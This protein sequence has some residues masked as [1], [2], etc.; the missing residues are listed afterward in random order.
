MLLIIEGQRNVGKTT[1]IDAFIA[2]NTVRTSPLWGRKI[3]KLSKQRMQFP[4]VSMMR[5]WLPAAFDESSIFILDRGHLTEQVYT[6]LTGRPVTWTHQEMSWAEYFLSNANAVTVYLNCDPQV[7][8]NR[9]ISTGKESEGEIFTI[10][11]LFEIYY[12]RTP[13][14]KYKIDVTEMAVDKV[15]KQLTDITFDALKNYKRIP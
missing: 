4:V 7:L 2:A 9:Q 15:V 12:K 8:Y 3:E 6:E 1:A 11:R 14:S 13:V 5:D 10:W